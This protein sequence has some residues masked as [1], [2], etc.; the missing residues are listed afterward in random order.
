MVPGM[1]C[2]GV[3]VG[4]VVFW[5]CAA[6]PCVAQAYTYESIV[7]DGCHERITSEALRRVRAELGLPRAADVGGQDE[8]LL[9]D[10][11]FEIEND[12]D[13]FDGASLLIGVRDNDLKGRH[14]IDSHELATVHGDPEGQREHCLRRG[15][16][17]EPGGS[18]E[19][20]EE[21]KAYIAEMA[22]HAVE[23]GIGDDGLPDRGL[24]TYVDVHL[25]LA[26]R[27]QASLPVFWVYM[28]QA[29]HTLQDSFTHAFRTGD[30][31][32]Q[33]Q[34][35]GPAD[36]GP[37]DSVGS[38]MRVS[39]LLNWQDFVD[40][41]LVE[42]RDGP[43]HMT[44]LDRC[45]G[46]DSFLD[47]RRRVAVDASTDLL[48]TAANP[49]RAV[50]DRIRDID[51]V[52]DRYLTARKPMCDFLT[53][54][55][56]APEN[57]YRDPTGCG[58][59]AGGVG[60]GGALLGGLVLLA[61]WGRRRRRRLPGAIVGLL[62]LGAGGAAHAQVPD[63]PATESAATEDDSPPG[64]TSPDSPAAPAARGPS[65]MPGRQVPCPCP[66][67]EQGAQRCADDGRSYGD[68]TGC[69]VS[70][71]EE[72]GDF[73]EAEPRRSPFGLH[74]AFG[75]SLDHAALAASA[76]GRYRLNP[77]WIAG[78]DA[79]FNPWVSLESKRVRPGTFNAYATIIRRWPINDFVTLRTTAH[80]G[81]SALLFSLYGAPAGT[82]GP[83]AGVSFIGVEFKV[84]H[85]WRLLVEPGDIALSVPHLTG[86]PL[87]YR[88]YRFTVGLQLGG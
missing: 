73:F 61:L 49:T 5:T 66:E 15:N 59:S 36:S 16:Q 43:P 6:W 65:C 46:V 34:D 40:G 19:A 75:A 8:A 41:K 17:D 20:L 86:A 87:T 71:E 63:P 62:V 83:Y 38:H 48:L 4:V 13:D 24:R 72:G 12:V 35:A 14:G 70:T 84:N 2:R 9:N 77:Y 55:C 28:G 68:C 52:L 45:E 74:T 39:V 47:D 54:W 76:G 53:R 7:S 44:G 51:L 56:D 22:K 78:V 3:G 82:F 80:L 11:P 88:Q 23:F 37:A 10:L 42:R 31:P 32:D 33:W 67:G 58:C 21:C 1:G 29:M 50:P 60:A 18:L 30:G 64:P 25:S 27:V 85:A 57:A 26:G 69:D 81:V 79:E